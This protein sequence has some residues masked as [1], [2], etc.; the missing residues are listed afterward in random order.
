MELRSPVMPRVISPLFLLRS[1]VSSASI[2]EPGRLT[3]S[4]QAEKKK[5]LRPPTILGSPWPGSNTHLV[6][7]RVGCQAV[8]GPWWELI[9]DVWNNF[10]ISG[11]EVG[12]SQ[13]TQNSHPHASSAACSWPWGEEF[14]PVWGVWELEQACRA[15][16]MGSRRCS[17]SP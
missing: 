9:N 14:H 4:L 13:A 6:A 1:L 15:W 10:T 3:A 12:Y 2:H 5:N 16:D 7:G 17:L 11:W 8:P